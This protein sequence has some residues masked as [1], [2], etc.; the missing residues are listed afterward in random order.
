ML[1]LLFEPAVLTRI[2]Y[3]SNSLSLVQGKVDGKRAQQL[4]ADKDGIFDIE[5]QYEL[6]VTKTEQK[7]VSRCR[8]RSG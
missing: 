7:P 1:P 5:V 8:C 3:P 4:I 2:T 6:R